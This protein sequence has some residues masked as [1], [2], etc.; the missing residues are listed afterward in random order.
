MQLAATLA[1]VLATVSVADSRMSALSHA[2]VIPDARPSAS[3]R[4]VPR[5]P[6]AEE[7]KV[8][9][10]GPLVRSAVGT[11]MGFRLSDI[12]G[13]SAVRVSMSI[14][15][16]PDCVPLPF[17]D[18]ALPSVM[19]GASIE[20]GLAVTSAVPECAAVSV[21]LAVKAA[22]MPEI[23]DV[24]PVAGP[25]PDSEPELGFVCVAYPVP[26]SPPYPARIVARESCGL[27]DEVLAA[28]VDRMIYDSLLDGTIDVRAPKWRMPIVKM[29]V[30]GAPGVDFDY[31]YTL[32]RKS[33]GGNDEQSKIR[34]LAKWASEKLS[35]HDAAD[36]YRA[37]TRYWLELGDASMAVDAALR[38][39]RARPDYAVRAR[40]LSALAYATSGD[41]ARARSEI[42]RSRAEC[43]PVSWERHELLYLEAWI[44]LQEG[45]AAA[46]ERN[47]RLIV[48]EGPG[49]ETGRKA[50]AVLRSISEEVK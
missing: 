38:M 16:T 26:E 4:P 25:P 2:I 35:P 18:L 20:V 29:L 22:P 48:S 50:L 7:R 30:D 1:V 37:E 41:F 31:V 33:F 19:A 49:S 11:R 12:R 3:F 47:L 43:S 23:P 34:A 21:G 39:E 32:L 8:T 46:A 36:V 5:S 28:A 15:P 40:R 42:A 17:E 45:D 10:P 27:S 9:L 24:S 44:W 6:D 13:A 14:G